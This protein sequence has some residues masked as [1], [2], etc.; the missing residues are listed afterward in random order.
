VNPLAFLS[1]Q[2]PDGE[3]LFVDATWQDRPEWREG[4]TW[5]CY[6]GPSL[7][8]DAPPFP[9]AVVRTIENAGASAQTVDALVTQDLPSARLHR[10]ATTTIVVGAH[11]MY[12]SVGSTHLAVQVQRGMYE[13][14]IWV[15]SA[16][17]Q[18]VTEVAFRLGDRNERPES[19]PAR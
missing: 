6:W 17:P 16:E 13:L 11:G 19:F 12:L 1:N 5:A 2:Q 3:V 10:V 14:E 7:V 8:A 18:L 4:D 15:D 9:G